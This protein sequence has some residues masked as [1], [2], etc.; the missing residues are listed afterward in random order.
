MVQPSTEPDAMSCK[1]GLLDFA[2]FSADPDRLVRI[3]PDL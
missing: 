2:K 3:P 1:R